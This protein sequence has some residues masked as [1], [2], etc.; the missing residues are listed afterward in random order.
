M[1]PFDAEGVRVPF[2]VFPMFEAFALALQHQPADSKI[3]TELDLY[4]LSRKAYQQMTERLV[5]DS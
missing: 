3:Q 2:V 4:S 5:I 1:Q